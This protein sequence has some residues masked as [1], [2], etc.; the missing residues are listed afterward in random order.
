MKRKEKEP[1]L[2]VK[3]LAGKWEE[4]ERVMEEMDDLKDQ[5]DDIENKAST[6][7]TVLV[8]KASLKMVE[9]IQEN[10]VESCDKFSCE[11]ALRNLKVE[12]KDEEG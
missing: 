6:F 2:K 3:E 12:G 4:L 11:Q 9:D 10:M 7:I 1:T 8:L 5:L